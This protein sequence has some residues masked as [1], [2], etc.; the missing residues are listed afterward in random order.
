MLW[1]YLFMF[2]HL[3]QK[4]TNAEYDQNLESFGFVISLIRILCIFQIFY[5]SSTN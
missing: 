3:K 2:L 1:N 5:F 4:N